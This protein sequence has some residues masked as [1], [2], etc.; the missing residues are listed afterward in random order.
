MHHVTHRVTYHVTLSQKQVTDHWT[1]HV[2]LSQGCRLPITSSI[3]EP[4]CH[5]SVLGDGGFCTHIFTF[6][7]LYFAEC[8]IKRQFVII[9][10]QIMKNSWL[11]PL[12]QF[13]SR[14]LL[15]S[16]FNWPLLTGYLDHQT[17]WQGAEFTWAANWVIG[18][19]PSNEL[20]RSPDRL[21][22]Y[23][24]HQTV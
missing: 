3:T 16:V 2:T 18:T 11:N 4:L 12:T 17:V 13:L 8:Q 22:R 23:L 9:I 5:F 10:N 24:D 15:E 7:V 1:R 19:R 20:T 21:T 6:S 14:W